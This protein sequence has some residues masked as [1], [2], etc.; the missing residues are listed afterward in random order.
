MALLQTLLNQLNESGE[1]QFQTEPEDQG[2]DQSEFGPVD[3]EELDQFD[4]RDGISLDTELLIKLLEWAH[5]EAQ[6]DEDLHKVVENLMA[7]GDHLTM[8]DF[9][10]AIE[11]LC[12][13]DNCGEDEDD[14]YSEPQGGEDRGTFK[15]GQGASDSDLDGVVKSA[16]QSVAR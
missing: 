8:E 12:Q 3:D 16:A 1:F 13:D 11:G 14:G 2:T 9:E 7:K 15:F 10:S 4:D 5:E 6:S